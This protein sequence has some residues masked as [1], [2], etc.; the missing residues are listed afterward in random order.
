MPISVSFAQV[1]N[2]SASTTKLLLGHQ[3]NTPAWEYGYVTSQGA[4]KDGILG[5]EVDGYAFS[6]VYKV[7]IAAAAGAGSD[8]V[9]YTEGEVQALLKGTQPLPLVQSKLLMVLN[10]VH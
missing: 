10:Q 6:L 3:N 4:A 1:S 2:D 8:G 5:Y 7:T 9:Q